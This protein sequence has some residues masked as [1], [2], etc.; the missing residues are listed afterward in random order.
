MRHPTLAA[1]T[2]NALAIKFKRRAASPPIGGYTWQDGN[3]ALLLD[4]PAMSGP[5]MSQLQDQ[6]SELLAARQTAVR[7]RPASGHSPRRKSGR[8]RRKS[9]RL[10]HEDGA[11]E[12][13]PGRKS[14]RKVGSKLAAPDPAVAD[15]ERS[16]ASPPASE[17]AAHTHQERGDALEQSPRSR[18]PRRSDRQRSETKSHRKRDRRREPI[19]RGADMKKRRSRRSDAD[20]G[21][22][23]AGPPGN[24]HGALQ[25][26][27]KSGYDVESLLREERRPS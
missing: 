19:E 7:S 5:D 11:H 17:R 12:S 14:R 26:L 2:S 15:S 9:K 23:E 18:S 6:V 13:S 21:E 24:L 10:R 25:T 16:T 3:Q 1:G 22:I 27:I 8:E 4:D 20:A